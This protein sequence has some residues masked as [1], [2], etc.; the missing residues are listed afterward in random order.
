MMKMLIAHESRRVFPEG[1]KTLPYRLRRLTLGAAIAGLV[2][3][4]LVKAPGIHAQS[5]PTVAA[6]APSFEVA[7]VKPSPLPDMAKLRDEVRAGRMMR[8]GPY[9]NAS[10]AEYI[11]MPLRDLIAIA[12]KVKPYEIIGPAWLPEDRFDIVAKMPDG[13]SKDDAPQM[14]KSLLEDRF[15]LATHRD[16]REHPVLALVVAKGGPK[17]KESAETLKPIDENAPLKP[18]ETKIDTLEG[19]VRITQNADGS[20]TINAGAKGTF[21]KKEDWEARTMTLASSGLTMA[22]FVDMLSNLLEMREGV[23]RKVVDRTGLKG[24]YQVAIVLSMDDGTDPPIAP[25]GG[26]G[27]SSPASAASE[28]SGGS[29]VFASVKKLGLKLEPSKAMVEQLVIDHVEQ[30]PTEN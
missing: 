25:A 16:L 15:K 19:P 17:L 30:T 12:Y 8:F 5:A 21:T 3:I 9:V 20:K 6:P 2:A 4:G 22:G 29:T 24:R 1:G 14:L 7:S 26:A 27:G 13:A 11:Y 28:P 18:G 10:R 23:G